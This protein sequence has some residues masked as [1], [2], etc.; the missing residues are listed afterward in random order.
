M[1]NR[2]G[3]WLGVAAM[4]FLGM[5]AAQAEGLKIAAVNM[6]QVLRA[7]PDTVNA[8]TQ[9]QKQADDF[10]QESKELSDEIDKLKKEF[11][12]ARE[13]ASD[14]ALSDEGRERKQQELA[15]KYRE[16]RER[17]QK[18]RET[19]VLR[20]QQL[21][22]QGRRMRERIVEKI[23]EIVKAYAAEKNLDLVLDMSAQGAGGYDA[24]V[25]ADGKLDV[26][27]D[28]IARVKKSKAD[29]PEEAAVK[30]E[31]SE[32]SAATE[33]AEKVGKTDK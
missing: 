29:E 4:V 33:A 25:F 32:T 11:E 12:A 23:R 19:L 30:S 24:V 5:G 13:S 8:E 6:S 31:T 7:H 15:D 1:S 2:M 14:K 3:V 27:E 26:T 16:L 10:E 22:D 9:L 20:K 17:D 21:T 28:I 18:A